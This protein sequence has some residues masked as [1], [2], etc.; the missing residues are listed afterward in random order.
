MT[1]MSYSFCT[2]SIADNRTRLVVAFSLQLR[3]RF[4]R[5]TAGSA[6]QPQIQ[7][8]GNQQITAAAILFL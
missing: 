8:H 1:R 7:G 5:L 4:W 2:A 3:D 6:N